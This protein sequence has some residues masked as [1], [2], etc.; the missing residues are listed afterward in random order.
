MYTQH[1]ACHAFDTFAHNLNKIH[2]WYYTSR[3][4]DSM[5]KQWKWMKS[6]SPLGIWV[7]DALLWEQHNC[8]IYVLHY[9]YRLY[10]EPIITYYIAVKPAF[11]GFLCYGVS[12]TAYRRKCSD[13]SV[14]MKALLRSAMLTTEATGHTRGHNVTMLQGK[15]VQGI[16]M[17]SCV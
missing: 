2:I 3:L 10:H 5:L 16:C 9:M 8:C 15:F 17:H 11:G 4:K 1:N 14:S 7:D 12:S 13:T 6:Q